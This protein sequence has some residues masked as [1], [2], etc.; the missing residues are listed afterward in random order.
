MEWVNSQKRDGDVGTSSKNKKVQNVSATTSG[1]KVTREKGVGYLRH[2]TQSMRRIARLPAKDREEVL[3]ALKRN[4]KRRTGALVISHTKVSNA[5]SSAP[6]DSHVLVNNEWSN[7]LTLH[8]SNKVANEDI[9]GIGKV[10]GLNFDGFNHNMFEVLS[11]GGRHNKEAKEG[12][13]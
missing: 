5:G 13:E 6:S 11:R 4:V 9:R 7:W 10:I 2:T 3:R 1:P 8:G 12:G